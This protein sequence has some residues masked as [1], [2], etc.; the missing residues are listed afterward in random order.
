MNQCLGLFKLLVR[1]HPLTRHTSPSTPSPFAS[2][3]HVSPCVPASRP[4][5]GPPIWSSGGSLRWSTSPHAPHA[6]PSAGRAQARRGLQQLLH[7]DSCLRCGLQPQ[8][9]NLAAGQLGQIPRS[10]EPT[11]RAQILSGPANDVFLRGPM[12]STGQA[13]LPNIESPCAANVRLARVAGHFEFRFAARRLLAY[14]SFLTG[15]CLV[16]LS[17]T[18]ASSIGALCFNVLPSSHAQRTSTNLS[19]CSE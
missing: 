3:R 11:S 7:H 16:T 2:S 4:F 19:S 9:A 13:H 17:C 10:Q 12:A 1:R 6:Q 15:I 8:A 18:F 5:F 14:F